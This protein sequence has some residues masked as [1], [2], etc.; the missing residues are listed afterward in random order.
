MVSSW[1]TDGEF[2]SISERIVVAPSWGRWVAEPLCEGDRV[3]A[4][5]VVGRVLDNGTATML[6]APVDG[7]FQGWLTDQGVRVRPGTALARF[8]IAEL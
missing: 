8:Q 5:A 1:H 3:A 4:G 6:V 7:V 2:L